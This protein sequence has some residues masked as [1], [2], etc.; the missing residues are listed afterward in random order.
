MD[1]V[2]ESLL[3]VLV[4]VRGHDSRNADLINK[5]RAAFFNNSKTVVKNGSQVDTDALYANISDVLNGKKHV[6]S[7]NKA[8]VNIINQIED[9]LDEN[10][11]INA[12]R[13]E[14]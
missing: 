14:N 3:A 4:A 10:L 12:F 5:V 1:N 8:D 11:N 9:D 2:V 6:D 13:G 7:G